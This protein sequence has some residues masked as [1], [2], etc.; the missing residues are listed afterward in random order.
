MRLAK[1][2]VEEANRDDAAADESGEGDI[3]VDGIEGM[4]GAGDVADGERSADVDSDSGDDDDD[5][6]ALAYI[7]DD[8]DDVDVDDDNE[9]S[10]EGGVA[11]AEVDEASLRVSLPSEL[12]LSLSTARWLRWC[13]L[14]RP[15]TVRWFI[16]SI[17]VRSDD[18]AAS[19]GTLPAISFI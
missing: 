7:D 9:E 12:S 1:A 18:S 10:E 4:N 17:S 15:P 3:D 13:S 8:D 14:G 6:V 16:P 2:D 11:R 5:D 19:C